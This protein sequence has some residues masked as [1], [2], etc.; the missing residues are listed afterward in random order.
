MK[1]E[2]DK[3]LAYGGQALIEGVLM[4]DQNSYAFT[5]KQPDGFFFKEKK[6]YNSISKKIKF[7]KLPF[8]R[9]V[10]GL[11][12]NLYFGTKIL[13]RSAEL[14]FPE[15]EKNKN[16]KK[17]SSL[18][19]FLIISISLLFA[20]LIFN[21][22]PYI[23]ANLFK[24]NQNDNPFMFNIIAGTIRI[25]FFFIYLVL[26]SLAK[27]VQ[28]LF[29]YHGAEHMAIHTYEAK[30]ELTLENVQK[31]TRLH[32][33]C[34]TS[35]IFIVFLITIV[36]FPL[37]NIY[38]NHQIWYRELI[39]LGKLGKI[40]QTAI[41]IVS[42]IIIGMPIVAGISYELLKLSQRFQKNI[43]VKL[44]IA[45]GL[46][47]QLFTTKKPDNDMIKAAILS[48]NMLLGEE[49]IATIRKVEDSITVQRP[50][51]LSTLLINFL[52]L[53]NLDDI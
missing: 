34:G 25:I 35:F 31:K 9:G 37:F 39:N 53:L 8:L 20:L 24:V 50:I 13:N 22:L 29:G 4:R 28:R 2:K 21:A 30:E 14:A 16:N 47:F 44:L 45:P 7:F 6:D 18:E 48:L 43:I 36:V 1:N 17:S 27:D 41:H 5:V 3:N 26:I 51:I 32:P 38:F 10:V 49:D 12:E 33:R 15:E 52:F 40:I 11:I 19:N 46:F 23:L 42:H